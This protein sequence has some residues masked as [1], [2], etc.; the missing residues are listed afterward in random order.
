MFDYFYY[1]SI[2]IKQKLHSST[3]IRK[4]KIDRTFPYQYLHY[5][6]LVYI[7]PP[8]KNKQEK[9]FYQIP[10]IAL[11]NC[12]GYGSKWLEMVTRQTNLLTIITHAQVL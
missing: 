3:A 9:T 1:V 4:K 10:K 12:N 8:N 7:D 6:D 11:I 5:N 2:Y